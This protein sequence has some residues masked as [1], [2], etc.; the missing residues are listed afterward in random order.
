LQSATAFVNAAFRDSRMTSP[1]HLFL[2]VQST[3]R[4]GVERVALRLA[5]DWGTLG[6]RVTLVAGIDPPGWLAAPMPGVEAIVLGS[7]SFFT[8]GRVIRLARER[9]PDVIFCPGNHYTSRAGL[10]RI[11]LGR[12]SGDGGAPPIVW[13][14]SNALE[15]TDRGRLAAF[16]FRFWLRRHR[17]IFDAAVVMSDSVGEQTIRVAGF[18]P[19]RVTTIPNPPLHGDAAAGDPV[20][21]PGRFL[22]GIGRLERQKD[23]PLALR[24]FAALGD[25]DR[26]LYIL[27]EGS[28]RARLIALAA[29]MGLGARVHLPGF[30]GDVRPWLARA[31]LLL[32]T[33]LFEGTP[34]VVREAVAAGTPVV[35][36]M[37]S[38]AIPELLGTEG[39]LAVTERTPGALSAAIRQM[40]AAPRPAALAAPRDDA[41]P[42]ASARAYARLFACLAGKEA[43]CG[44]R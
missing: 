37:S 6:H 19:D 39:G 16:F 4:G 24:T 38:P 20:P 7:E 32:L 18:A 11:A 9:R 28:E 2:F 3:E 40:L 33:S 35:T 1:L 5:R 26:D 22:L 34:N 10:M 14:V 27:G 41:D 42:L 12:R 25:P 8:I 43:T 17:S 44:S 36:T 13:K 30:V 31:D 15:R 21:P 29:R 23:W